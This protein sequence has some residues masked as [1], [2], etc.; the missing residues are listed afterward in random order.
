MIFGHTERKPSRTAYWKEDTHIT[1]T[2]HFSYLQ[3]STE[4]LLYGYVRDSC[5]VN[6]IL[7]AQNVLL[8][9]EAAT[10]GVL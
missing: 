3:A 5:S 9:S 1:V 8:I 10:G 4:Y 2:L 7:F 6:A